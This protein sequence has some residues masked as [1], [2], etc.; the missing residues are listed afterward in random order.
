MRQKPQLFLCLNAMSKGTLYFIA[1]IPPEPFRQ[2]A[3][4][5]KEHF[6]DMYNSKASLNSPPHITMHP[7]FKLKQEE[8]E[9]E[10]EQALRQVASDF[11]PFE[12]H[13][14]NYG[15]FPPRVLFID[16]EKA[17]AMEKLQQAIRKQVVALAVEEKKGQETSFHPHMTLAFRD[18]SKASFHRAW[19]EYQ[20]KELQC[21]WEVRRFTLLKHNG[22]YWEEYRHCGLD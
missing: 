18:L 22:K 6:R 11:E 19:K 7:P 20:A 9:K 17:P 14:K 16:V 2:K 21:S 15:A 13:L 8:G 1:L 3:W 12:A 10:L 5:M 4:E